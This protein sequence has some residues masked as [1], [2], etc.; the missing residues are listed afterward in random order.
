MVTMIARQNNWGVVLYVMAAFASLAMPLVLAA[1]PHVAASA[2]PQPTH[3]DAVGEARSIYTSLGGE[4]LDRLLCALS[5][6]SH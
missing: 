2:F 6:H 4:G 3:E 1:M 5:P